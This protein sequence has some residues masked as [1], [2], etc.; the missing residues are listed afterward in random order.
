MTSERLDLSH[1]EITEPPCSEFERVV[2]EALRAQ[3]SEDSLRKRVE[4]L[5]G[6]IATKAG[7]DCDCS[8]GFTDRRGNAM[9]CDC[10][11]LDI[12]ESHQALGG[13]GGSND[14]HA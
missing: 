12:L 13:A 8:L 11:F 3:A 10:G 1:Y 2:L 5:E 4:E 6:W 14:Q 7:H 9:V